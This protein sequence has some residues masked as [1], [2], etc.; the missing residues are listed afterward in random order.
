VVRRRKHLSLMAVCIQLAALGGYAILGGLYGC[1]PSIPVDSTVQ[2]SAPP[3]VL[4]R[5]HEGHG[6]NALI[7]ESEGSSENS[8]IGGEWASQS[9]QKSPP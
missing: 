3:N 9:L 8:G 4:E 5:S 6:P 2:G 1:N 7:D